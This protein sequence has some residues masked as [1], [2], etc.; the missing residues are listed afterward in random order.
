MSSNIRNIDKGTETAYGNH[1]GRI[2]DELHS[3]N[4]IY[5]K[6][7]ST[8]QRLNSTEMRSVMTSIING[9]CS[10]VFIS[11]FLMALILN[12]EDHDELKAAAEIIRGSCGE[13]RACSRRRPRQRLSSL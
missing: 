8:G 3:Q 11:A 6:K 7:L 9:L 5:L 2:G 10:D 4:Q 12:G 13:D 1:F